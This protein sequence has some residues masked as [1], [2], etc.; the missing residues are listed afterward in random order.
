MK[1]I[2]FEELVI[3]DTYVTH[4]GERL[5]TKTETVNEYGRTWFKVYWDKQER[6]DY[7]TDCGFAG[8]EISKAGSH[9]VK[10]TEPQKHENKGV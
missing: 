3:G 10:I 2:T 9:I 6:N 5:V 1:H 4:Y 8:I 7:G